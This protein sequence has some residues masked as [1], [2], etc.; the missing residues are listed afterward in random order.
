MPSKQIVIY[1]GGGCA[2]EVAWLIQS[3]NIEGEKYRVACFADDD[4]TSHGTELNGIPIM[5][6]ETARSY[7]RSFIHFYPLYH[8]TT[9]ETAWSHDLKV[10]MQVLYMHTLQ[11]LDMR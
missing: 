7:I 9:I 3:C 5:S 11:A 10:I 6:L 8:M 4:E 1:G 2:R